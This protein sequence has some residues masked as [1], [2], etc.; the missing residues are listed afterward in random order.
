MN[1]IAPGRATLALGTGNLFNF[2]TLTMGTHRIAIAGNNSYQTGFTDTASIQ[3]NAEIV[4]NSDNSFVVFS[5]AAA[6]S[7]D[8]AGRSLTLIKRGVWNTVARDVISRRSDQS[9]QSR[10]RDWHT[11]LRG[12][13]GA[14]TTGF[15][16]AAPSSQSM[17]RPAGK[18][19]TLPTQG[20]LNLDNNTGHLV[21]ATTVITAANN[22]D[23]IVDSAI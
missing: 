7:E 3:G 16:G 5:N 10:S 21:G 12:A 2:G 18:W 9:F 11:A 4:M 15:G 20:L 22:N 1:I 19:A 13:A 14:I 23:R 8:A 17:A 6:I